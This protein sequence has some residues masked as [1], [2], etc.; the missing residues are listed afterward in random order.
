MDDRPLSRLLTRPSTDIAAGG[1]A[2]SNETNHYAAYGDSPAWISKTVARRSLRRRRFPGS[3]CRKTLRRPRRTGETGQRTGLRCPPPLG[4]VRRVQPLPAQ[5]RALRTGVGATVVLGPDRHLVLG[6]EASSSRPSRR[7]LLSDMH[8]PGATAQQSSSSSESV[9]R[10]RP[11]GMKVC[12][13][14]APEPDRQ[15]GGGERLGR[16]PRRRQYSCRSPARH[17]VWPAERTGR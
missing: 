13:R 5:Q 15:G 10:S 14:V 4:D 9:I 7:V 2:T 12:G 16:C 1:S 3:T 8:H 6:R 11:A 17:T